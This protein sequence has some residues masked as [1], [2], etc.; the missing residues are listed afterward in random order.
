SVTAFTAD[1]TGL[2]ARAAVNRLVLHGCT[3]DPGGALQLDGTVDGTRQAMCPGLHLTND[4]GFDN[5]PEITAFNQIPDI[6][7][8]RSTCGSSGASPVDRMTWVESI[9]AAGSGEEAKSRALAV[10]AAT[11]DPETAWGPDLAVRGM[12]CF[13]RMR[14]T[15]VDGEGGIWVHRL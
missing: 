11:G 15:R 9:I 1:S 12:T 7:L 2:I 4:Y 5:T 6:E 8:H 13:G 3:L 14:V 10:G